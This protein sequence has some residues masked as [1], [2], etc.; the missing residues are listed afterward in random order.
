MKS[1][2]FRS[3][4]DGLLDRLKN[5]PRALRE[6]NTLGERERTGAWPSYRKNEFCFS[7]R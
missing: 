7:T 6:R 4:L 3:P 1:C 2:S 5:N